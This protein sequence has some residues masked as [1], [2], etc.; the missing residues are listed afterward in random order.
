MP[1]FQDFIAQIDKAGIVIE[2][3]DLF[4]KNAE[5]AQD[6]PAAVT[7]MSCVGV[8]DGI[9]LTRK[10]DGAPSNQDVDRILCGYPF[11]PEQRGWV[12]QNVIT[13]A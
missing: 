9:Q 13:V 6:W 7:K 1:E 5:A 2:G 10:A 8:K 4:I 3:R 11:T 12:V